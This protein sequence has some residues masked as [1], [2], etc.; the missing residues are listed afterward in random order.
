MTVSIQEDANLMKGWDGQAEVHSIYE[1]MNHLKDARRK[2]GKR[3]SMALILTYLLLGKAAGE[4]TLQAITEWIRLRGAWLQHVLPEAGPHFPCAATYSNVL[5]AVDPEHLNAVLMDLLTRMRAQER[6]DGE[7]QHVA[8]DGKTLR[9][10]QGHLAEDQKKM[11]QV[12]LY[13]TQ[14]GI[15][16][17]EHIV[18]DKENEVSRVGEFLKPQWIQG[19]IV[20]ADAMYTQQGFCLGVTMGGGM[21]VLFAKGNQPTLQEDLHLF[22]EEPPLD[23]LD[24]RT[25]STCS[26]GHGRVEMRDLVASTELNDFLSR[27]WTGIAQVFRLR[28]RVCKPLICTQEVVYGFTSLPAAQAGPERLLEVIRNHWAIENRLHRRRDGTLQEDNCQVRKG[29]A[30]R[31]LTLLNSFLLALFDWLEVTNVASFMRTVAASPIR[32]LRLFFLSLERIK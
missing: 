15:V 5:R 16:L 12:S 2:Q 21:Y 4:T 32:A 7:Q 17:K 10:T 13:E 14:T 27:S 19:R 9:G 6:G 18:G 24:W 3:Y 30:P 23:C 26:S 28:R 31:T 11:H 1:A 8:L 25:A 20:S 22:F 29:M